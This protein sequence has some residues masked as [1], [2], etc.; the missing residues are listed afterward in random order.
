MKTTLIILLSVLSLSF[1]QAAFAQKA[2]NSKT[3]LFYVHMH[4][5]SC[6]ER[7]EKNIAFE[8][9][10]K[11]MEVN[12]D[13]KTVTITYDVRKTSDEKLLAAFNKLDYEA[14]LKPLSE[15]AN[16]EKNCPEKKRK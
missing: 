12:F 11:D 6:K 10:V 2:N 1:T 5:I 13:A 7:I 9:G 16:D 8:K 14:S 4:C 15:D 3:T